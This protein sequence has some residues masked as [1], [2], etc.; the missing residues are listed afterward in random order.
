MRN[1]ALPAELE[2]LIHDVIGCCLA[3]HKELGPGLN[4]GIYQRALKLEFGAQKLPFVEEYSVPIRYRGQLL[5]HQR[6]DLFV[7]GQIVL[8]VKSVEQIHPVHVAQTVGYLRLTGA[9]AGLLVD[10]N[11]ALLREGIRRVVL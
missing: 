9:R 4:E 2:T 6:I 3:V 11:V 1:P 8:E 5:A 7:D 10:F